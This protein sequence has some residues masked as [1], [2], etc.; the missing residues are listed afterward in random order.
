MKN[1]EYNAGYNTGFKWGM[2]CG[3]GFGMIVTILFICGIQQ[4][5]I[6]HGV[7]RFSPKDGM[8]E[9]ITNTP[10]TNHDQ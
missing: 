1:S 2:F 8:F 10:S 9:W 4:S 3:F 6:Q 7:A 5:A